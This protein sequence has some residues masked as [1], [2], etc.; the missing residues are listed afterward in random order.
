MPAN[1][2]PHTAVTQE[3]RDAAMAMLSHAF[4]NAPDNCTQNVEFDDIAMAFARSRLAH[5]PSPELVEALTDGILRH[6]AQAC[7]HRADVLFDTDND[8]NIAALTEAVRQ[9][10]ATLTKSGGAV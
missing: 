9:A 4:R 10:L 8:E 7:G 5:T 1:P 3:D 6:V 2:N